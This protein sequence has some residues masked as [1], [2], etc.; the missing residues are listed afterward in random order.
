MTAYADYGLVWTPDSE[1]LLWLTTGPSGHSIVSWDLGAS[2]VARIVGSNADVPL[3]QYPNYLFPTLD[4]ASVVWI[5]RDASARQGVAVT[6]L[7]PPYATRILSSESGELSF[8]GIGRI[9]V[10]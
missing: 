5:Q 8:A 7:D 9:E 3:E 4:S 2:P 10:R 1:H 6:D